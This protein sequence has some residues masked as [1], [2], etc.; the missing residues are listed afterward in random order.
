MG[1]DVCA[2]GD[3]GLHPET[4]WLG[5]AAAAGW[6]WHPGSPD[7]EEAKA[8]FYRLFYG[9]GAQNI[10]RLY[11]LMSTQ[12]EFWASSWDWGPSSLRPVLFGDSDG[13]R[14]IAPRDQVIS[15]PP[16]PNGDYLRLDYDWAKANERRLKL[17]EEALSDNDELFGLLNRNL[18]AVEFHSYN[19]EVFLSIARLYRQNLEMLRDLRAINA[20][21][22]LAET[23]AA[24]LDYR[25]AIS[26]LDQG[27][28]LAYVIRAHRNRALQNAVSTWYKSWYPRVGQ[29]NGRRYLLVLNSVQ[30]Y[31]VDRTLG[32]NYLIQREFLLPF[33][34]WFK[35]LQEVRNRYAALHQLS[36]TQLQFDWQDD[37]TLS[38]GSSY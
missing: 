11:Q 13:I 31:R 2:W 4:F 17:S 12:A 6:I 23:A 27:L 29:A 15:L 33:G 28:Q 14:P 36:E 7:P 5:F 22:Q 25:G 19:L 26:S 1:V 3:E 16:L 35:Q 34:D 38:L 24:K 37:S 30:D 21:L 32:L 20:S 10:G 8:S 18:N 9:R